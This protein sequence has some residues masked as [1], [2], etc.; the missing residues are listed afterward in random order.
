[1]TPDRLAHIENLTRR[2]ARYRPCGAGLGALWGGI[3]YQF[4]A[5][6]ALGW[7]L[8]QV[9]P[10][11]TL[12]D[13]ARALFRSQAHLPR[14]LV[15]S[16]IAAPLL[17]WLGVY[18]IQRGVD[19]RFGRVV[20]EPHEG[21]QFPRWLLPGFVI[22]V[23]LITLA[24]G[25][26]NHKALFP[27]DPAYNLDA[28]KVGG[29]LSIALLALLWGRAGQDQQTRTLMMLASL[30]SILALTAGPADLFMLSFTSAAYLILMFAAMVKGALRF[31]G[32]LKV[33]RELDALQPEGE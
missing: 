30:P 9:E 20:G 7:V 27:N 32:F 23:G 14:L 24:F 3:V 5:G 12:R 33:S 15:V 17:I 28:W 6:M 26:F 16:A 18:L 21:I 11:A 25:A 13:F 22:L 2:Y 1:M 19:R 10:C 29:I 4:F 8:R 31:G